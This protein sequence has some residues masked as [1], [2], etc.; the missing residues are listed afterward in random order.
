MVNFALC[1]VDEITS[2]CMCT[3]VSWSLYDEN[4]FEHVSY[5]W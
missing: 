3:I 5:V 1:D 2:T 4:I